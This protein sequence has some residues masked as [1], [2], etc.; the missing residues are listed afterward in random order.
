[1]YL[2][3]RDLA[4]AQYVCDYILHGGDKQEFLQKFSNATSQGMRGW[5]WMGMVHASS[6]LRHAAGTACLLLPALT[7]RHVYRFRP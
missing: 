6:V 1:M 2:I 4:E 5:L 3:I 7:L